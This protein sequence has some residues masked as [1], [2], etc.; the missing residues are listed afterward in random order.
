MRRDPFQAIADPTRRQIIQLLAKDELAVKDISSHFP[1]S[2][3]AISKH[4]RILRQAKLVSERK[5]GKY[6]LYVL[7]PERLQDLRAW[8]TYFD[9]FWL[10]KLTNLKEHIEKR[11]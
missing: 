7:H 11:S 8:V 1:I 9:A 10:D 4:L 3:P 2:R 5:H 6:R